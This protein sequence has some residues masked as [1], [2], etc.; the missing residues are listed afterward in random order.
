LLIQ[1]KQLIQ[2]IKIENMPIKGPPILPINLPK[3]AKNKKLI[4]GDSQVIKK[5]SWP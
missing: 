5:V 4:N 2:A 3:V 1:K